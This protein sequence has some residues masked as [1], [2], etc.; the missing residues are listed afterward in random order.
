MIG[1]DNVEKGNWM[2]PNLATI[3][4]PKEEMGLRA[5]DLMIRR[6]EKPEANKELVLVGTDIVKRD[7]VIKI[8]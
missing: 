4:I 5:V 2:T 6:I 1:F 8:K 3:N 7:S